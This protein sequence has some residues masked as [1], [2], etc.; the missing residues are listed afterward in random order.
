MGDAA[1]DLEYEEIRRALRA[2][3]CDEHERQKR[4]ASQRFWDDYFKKEASMTD[5]ERLQVEISSLRKELS[6]RDL[7]IESLTLERDAAKESRDQMERTL[8]VWKANE[9]R[10]VAD[11]LSRK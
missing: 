1:D 10:R 6:S 3:A 2:Q 9:A 11:A 5:I 7:R 8:S 4:R